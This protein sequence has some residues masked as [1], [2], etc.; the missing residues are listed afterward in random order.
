MLPELKFRPSLSAER[1]FFRVGTDEGVAGTKVPALIER[2]PQGLPPVQPSEVLPELKFRP[3]L[4]ALQKR[5]TK[6]FPPVLPELKFRPSLSVSLPVKLRVTGRVLPELK[7]RPSL[8][9]GG[10]TVARSRRRGVL[11]ELKFR[12]SLSAG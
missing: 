7:F 2:R 3:S 10:G 11:P 1:V 9:G 6:I 4:S 5:G 12:P 8:S